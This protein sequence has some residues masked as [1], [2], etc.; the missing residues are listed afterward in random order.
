[1]ETLTITDGTL[2]DSMRKL[3]PAPSIKQSLRR[4]LVS[5]SRSELIKYTLI[6]R[7]FER[8][9]KMDF[10]TFRI[11]EQMKEPSFEVEQDYFDWELAVTKIA[12]MEEELERLEEISG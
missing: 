8:Q 1:M 11:S 2:I 9:Y 5:R 6:N 12:E 4:L 7:G 3:E 10:H